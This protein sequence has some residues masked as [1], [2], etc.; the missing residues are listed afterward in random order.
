MEN[1]KVSVIVPVYNVEK[2]LHRCLDSIINQTLKEIEII[3]VNDCST[4]SSLNI[5]E[6]YKDKEDRI[7]IINHQKNLRLA[8]ARNSGMKVAKGEYISFIDS[9]D[10]IEN[11]FS[12]QSYI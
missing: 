8:A 10:Y 3:C 9:D 7:I 2:Y 1:I 5:L 11:N 4:D 12:N 6:D